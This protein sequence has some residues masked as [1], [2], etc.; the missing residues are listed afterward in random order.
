M[1]F[2]KEEKELI[3]MPVKPKKT[4]IKASAPQKAPKQPQLKTPS[5]LKKAF[6]VG[7]GA[8]TLTVEKVQELMN[9]MVDKGEFSKKDAKALTED[10]RKKAMAEKQQLE[11]AMIRAVE[12]SVELAL[13]N[14][15][16]VTRKEFDAMKKELSGKPV[17]S[18]TAT[19]PKK[20]V[21]KT[22]TPKKSAPKPLKAGPKA[23]KAAPKAMKEVAKKTGTVLKHAK[24]AT[25]LPSKKPTPIKSRRVG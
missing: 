14:M 8:T 18:K 15:G 1:Y 12:A 11:K 9:E 22:S 3:L 5:L 21:K 6:L 24:K 13:K 10:F 19:A 17:V 23:V 2:Q 4:V 7:L 16:L 20:Q 25:P